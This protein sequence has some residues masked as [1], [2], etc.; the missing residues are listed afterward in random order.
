M[1]ICWI[2]LESIIN[3]IRNSSQNHVFT[4]KKGLGI[5]K[6]LTHVTTDCVDIIHKLLI[7]NPEE[8]FSAK[9]ALAHPFFKDLVEQELKLSKMSFNN[10]NFKYLSIKLAP[11]VL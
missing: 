5:S 1:K 7:Y 8:R 2:N 9:N 4:N 10:Y 6:F 11:R 3:L